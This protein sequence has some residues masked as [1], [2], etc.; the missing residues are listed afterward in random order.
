MTCIIRSAQRRAR[1]LSD[2]SIYLH[3]RV[4]PCLKS[5]RAPRAFGDDR[6]AGATARSPVGGR[7]RGCAA[8]V[9]RRRETTKLFEHAVRSYQYYRGM[10]RTGPKP[11]STLNTLIIAPSDRDSVASP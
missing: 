8:R 10:Q 3:G 11:S 6:A 4:A 5:V 7:A 2:A 1:T 9:S